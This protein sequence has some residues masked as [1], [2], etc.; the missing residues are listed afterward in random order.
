M[1]IIRD[2]SEAAV[3]SPL[4]MLPARYVFEIKLTGRD[5]ITIMET[6]GRERLETEAS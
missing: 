3:R 4:C 1:E 6:V 5:P 2:P